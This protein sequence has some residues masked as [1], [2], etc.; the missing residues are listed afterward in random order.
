MFSLLVKSDIFLLNASLTTPILINTFELNRMNFIVII[1]QIFLIG[2]S[3]SIFDYKQ[4]SH[5]F[6]F[7]DLI[8]RIFS[9]WGRSG[10]VLYCVFRKTE[11]L[12]DWELAIWIEKLTLNILDGEHLITLSF[13]ISTCKSIVVPLKYKLLPSYLRIC[14]LLLFFLP[15]AS[16]MSVATILRGLA[17]VLLFGTYSML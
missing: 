16:P 9:K 1:D 14:G 11:Y 3:V 15:D 5:G 2:L 4:C 13:H 7:Q 8:H 6:D 17:P 12:F 10:T